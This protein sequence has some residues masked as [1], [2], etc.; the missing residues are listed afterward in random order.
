VGFNLSISHPCHSKSYPL[1]LHFV[2]PFGPETSGSK[3]D[4]RFEGRLNVEEQGRGEESMFLCEELR[5]FSRL[6]RDQGDKFEKYHA[7]KK[8]FGF[9]VDR[10]SA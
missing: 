6:W 3:E 8:R 5:P 7:E 4:L 10:R 1:I 2:L 9:L